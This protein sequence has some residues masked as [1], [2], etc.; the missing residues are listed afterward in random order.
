MSPCPYLNIKTV[1]PC[2][3]IPMLKIR[4]SQDRL[5]FNMGIPILVRRH[6]YIETA[7]L[8]SMRNASIACVISMLRNHENTFHVSLTHFGVKGVNLQLFMDFGHSEWLTQWPPACLDIVHDDVI[9]WK[10]LPRY[11]P[12]VRGIH[13]STVNSSHQGQWRGALMFSLICAR[14]NGW[15]NNREAGDLRRHRCHYDVIVMTMY[16]GSHLIAP[17]VS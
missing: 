7:P 3:G 5:I 10:H 1:F 4:R 6:L 9:K 15:V 17:K 11:W 14:I 16:L 2:I 13:R 12:F 8:S